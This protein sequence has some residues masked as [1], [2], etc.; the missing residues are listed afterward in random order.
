MPVRGGG[1]GRVAR[2]VNSRAPQ[3]KCEAR[4][5]GCLNRMT[6][7]SALPA[8]IWSGDARYSLATQPAPVAR[9]GWVLVDVAFTGLCGTDL[10]IFRGE[11]PRAALGLVPGHEF[12]G[13]LVQATSSLPQGAPV[14][15]NPLMPCGACTSCR[16]ARPH[17]CD[18]LQLIGIDI[19]G[20]L[21]TRVA[22]PVQNLVPLPT[23]TDLRHAALVEPMAVAVRAVR[24]A[25]IGLGSRVVVIG[26]GPV[27][28][29]IARMAMGAGAAD[30]VL[31]EVSPDRRAS[32]ELLGIRTTPATRGD[33][34]ADVVVD[35]S[36]HSSVSPLLTSWVRTSGRMLVVGFHGVAPEPFDLRR[37]MVRELEMSGSCTYST[38]DV[39]VAAEIVASREYADV[40]DGVVSHVVGLAEVEAAMLDLE[41]GRG[42]KV[43]VDVRR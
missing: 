1:G 21:S 33:Q 28:C 5:L 6:T 15:V 41:S 42:L 31:S 24:R 17:L 4:S 40:L 12:S 27:G 11:H 38:A 7:P 30:V 20:A 10:H 14:F 34:G 36:G 39:D 43:L 35:A 19:P 18:R 26:A 23:G 13:T 2:T 9:E 32:A 16:H 29:L 8:I 22:V 3:D 37:V 25:G